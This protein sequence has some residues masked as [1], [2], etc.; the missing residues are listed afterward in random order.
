[1]GVVRGHSTVA[2]PPPC[3]QRSEVM[4]AVLPRRARLV[5]EQHSLARVLVAE[6]SRG[7]RWRADAAGLM[8]MQHGR[9]QVRPAPW[10]SVGSPVVARATGERWLFG[11]TEPGATAVV[12][13]WR[14]AGMETI[15]KAPGIALVDATCNARGCALLMH[16]PGEDSV[17]LGEIDV[18]PQTWLRAPLPKSA[19]HPRKALVV[20]APRPSDA[21]GSEA[22]VA[23]VDDLR[24]RFN[25]AHPSAPAIEIAA[26]A[27][28]HGALAASAE[29]TPMA[30][31]Y[32]ADPGRDGCASDAGGVM[33]QIAGHPNATL[34]SALAPVRGALHVL[35]GGVLAT[36]LSPARCGTALRVLH[37]A[38]L[39]DDGT[40]VAPVVTVADAD[41][42]AVATR[43]DAV[44]MWILHDRVLTYLR[45][46]CSLPH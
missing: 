6:G 15:A 17:W 18:A 29:R 41:D 23:S 14:G 20:S 8:S 35:D 26:L 33:I 19:S 44:D 13:L 40:P 32:L 38:L 12:G 42:Y 37:A 11:V 5:S 10:P 24:V 27:T 2:L 22:I 3:Q 9:C 4:R 34:R 16:T 36:W 25:R 30:M 46:R 1:M 21:G 39:R 45:V 31:S 7:A 28:P 43:A